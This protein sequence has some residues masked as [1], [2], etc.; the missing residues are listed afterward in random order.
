[1]FTSGFALLVAGINLWWVTLFGSLPAS[2]EQLF[3]ALSMVTLICACAAGPALTADCVNE[4]RNNGTLGFLFLTNLHP[5]SISLGKLAGHGI[6]ALYAIVSIVPVMALPLI[7]GGADASSLAKTSLV[8]GVTLT[9]SLALGM[10]ASTL[11]RK[12]WVAAALTL[13][14]LAVLTLGIPAADIL[15]QMN[16]RIDWAWLELF[17]P[18]Y[19]LSMAEPSAAML[20]SNHLWLALSAQALMTLACFGFTTFLLPRIWKEGKSENGL[21][22]LHSIWNT[23]NYGSGK[24]RDRLRA[25]LLKVNPILWLSSRKRWGPAG[26]ALVLLPLA[27]A[28][29]WIGRHVPIGFYPS[30]FLNPMRIWIAAMP[31]LYLGFC[32]RLAVAASERFAVDRKTGALEL[33]LCTPLSV[34]EILRGHWL[35]LIRRFW[36]AALA[37]LAMHGF[38]L[39]YI[40]EAI[41]LEGGL[42]SFTLR[43]ALVGAAR[44]VSGTVFIPNQ[45]VPFYIGTLAVL[46]AAV[47]MVALWIALVWLGTALSLKLRREVLAPWISL[48]LLAVP[49]IPVIIGF[50][51]LIVHKRLFATNLFLGLL[52]IG[53]TGFFVVLANAMIWLFIARRWTYRKFR[54]TA[55]SAFSGENRGIEPNP[56]NSNQIWKASGHSR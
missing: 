34:W 1:M 5:I 9:L 13:F 56:Q 47:L 17:S 23:W 10:L 26:P 46:M 35:G 21:H 22:N 32:F 8:L 16:Q 39:N 20:P 30:D 6:L 36:G 19:S 11:C 2:G 24:A 29:S 28:I 25:C 48:L 31:F 38:V 50:I 27:C 52:S 43:D 49:P 4:E 51:A 40:I 55:A 3:R 44:H 41:R 45:N 53:A 12:T 37:L 42:P 18:S 7:L 14:V 33:I 54:A 15:M